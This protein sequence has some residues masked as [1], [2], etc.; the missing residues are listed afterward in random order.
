[1]N[2]SKAIPRFKLDYQNLLQKGR[3]QVPINPSSH[4][5]KGCGGLCS[6][7]VA[8][9]GGP[10][11]RGGLTKAGSVAAGQLVAVGL[12]S[13]RAACCGRAR[14]RRAARGDGPAG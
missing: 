9:G 14:W 4:R 6:G 13:G 11:G 8:H 10:G 7:W 2:A 12:C 5:S 3:K 1:M